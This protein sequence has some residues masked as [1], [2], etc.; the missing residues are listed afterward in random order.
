MAYISLRHT[1][2]C[3]AN[4]LPESELGAVVGDISEGVAVADPDPN[5]GKHLCM[6]LPLFSYNDD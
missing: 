5:Q 4:E 3:L 6:L 2:L 1:F